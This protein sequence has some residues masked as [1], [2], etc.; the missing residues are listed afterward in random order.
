MSKSIEIGRRLQAI[1]KI[2]PHNQYEKLPAE[3]VNTIPWEVLCGD[4]IGPYTLK[5][6]DGDTR[7]LFVAGC[8]Y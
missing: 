7:F 6:K 5:V 3:L 8:C 2:T 4:P 1:R